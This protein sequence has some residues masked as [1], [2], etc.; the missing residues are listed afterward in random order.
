VA[1]LGKHIYK[2]KALNDVAAQAIETFILD[3]FDGMREFHKDFKSNEQRTNGSLADRSRTHSSS[4]TPMS[5]DPANDE[6]KN[7][8]FKK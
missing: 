2:I 5:Y 3:N 7:V 8:S 1:A 6:P 4:M